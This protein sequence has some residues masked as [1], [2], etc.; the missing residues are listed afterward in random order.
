MI[1]KYEIVRKITC[2]VLTLTLLISIMPSMIADSSFSRATIYVDDDASASWYDATHVKTIQEGINNA[3]TGDTVFVYNGTYYEHIIVNRTVNLIGENNTNTIIDGSDNGDVLTLQ[4]NNITIRSFTIQH[5]GNPPM[6]HS[7][8]FIN[9]NDNNIEDNIIIHNDVYGVNI[10]SASGNIIENNTIRNNGEGVRVFSALSNTISNNIITNNYYGIRTWYGQQNIIKHN[11]ITFSGYYGIFHKECH[12]SQIIN[13]TISNGQNNGYGIRLWNGQQVIIQQNIVM[14]HGIGIYLDSE[15]NNHTIFNNYFDNVNNVQDTGVDNSWNTTLTIGTNI[16]NGSYIGGNYWSDYLGYDSDADG[17]GDTDLPY[18]PGDYLP[19]VEANLIPQAN[20]TYAPSHPSTVDLIQFTDLS[21]DPDGTADI[22]NWTWD[23]GDG[24]ISYEQNATHSY[25]DNGNYTVTLFIYDTQGASNSTQQIITVSNLAPIADFSYN[26]IDPIT[27]DIVSFNSTSVDL[28]GIIVN[29]T[30]DFNDG[31]YGYGENISH[32]FDNGTF[33]VVLWVKDD[34]GSYNV[35]NKTITVTN[36]HPSVDF[37]Y[38][39]LNPTTSDTIYFEDTSSD[40][41]VRSITNW[42]WDFG[43][44]NNSYLQ[45]PTHSYADNGTYTVMLTVTDNNGASN[46]TSKNITVSNVA[47]MASFLFSPLNPTTI[48]HIQFNDT[49]TDSDG[50]VVNWSWDFGDGNNS[51]L[52][53]PTHSYA[54]NGTYIV[55][56]VV[57]DDDGANNATSVMVTVGNTPPI[58]NFSFSPFAPSTADTVLFNDTSFDPDGSVL[59][60]YWDFDDGT[61]NTSQNTSHSFAA[62]G[63]YNVS[64]TVT[65]ND[66]GVNMTT[67]PITVSNIGPTASFTYNPLHPSTADIIQ[68]TDTSTDSDGS[69]VNWTWDFGDGT[70]N[71][72]Q[73]PVHRFSDNGTYNVSL[74]IKDDNGENDTIWMLLNVSNAIPVPNFTWDPVNPTKLDVIQF[75]DL[76]SD[77]SVVSWNWN[78]GDGNLS[79]L[80]NPTH[81]Y[82]DDGLYNVTLIVSDDDGSINS[83]TKLLTV[84]SIKPDANFSYSPNN[85]STED[86]V[87]FTDLS[88]DADGSI[89]NWT[90]DFGDE[91]QSYLQHPSHQYAD[92]GSYIVTLTVVDDDGENDSINGV[93]DV[94]N[95]APSVNFSYLPTV[96]TTADVIQFT[97]L[98][99]DPDGTIVSWY[100]D[101][102]DGYQQTNQHPNNQYADDD[103]YNVSLTVTDDD[104]A[105][106]TTYKLITITNVAPLVS[107]TYTPIH[108]TVDDLILFNDTSLDSDG[109]IVN[110][111]W[112][113]G[114]GNNSY[115]K[116]PSFSYETAGNYTVNLTVRDDDNASN[117]S[118]ITLTI[119][120]RP[121][122]FDE[123]W[124]DDD[125]NSSLWWWQI[126]H[127]DSIQDAIDAVCENGTVYVAPGSYD[128]QLVINKSVTIIGNGTG[129]TIVTNTSTLNEF[130]TTSYDNYPIV[131]IHHTDDVILKNLSV[132]GAGNGNDN[133]RFIGVG[134]YDAGGRLNQIEIKSVR[135]TPWSGAQHGVSVYAYAINGTSRNLIIDNCEIYDYQKNAMSLNGVDLMVEVTNNTIV[136]NGPTNVT[137]Q[138]GIQV[139]S[140]ASGIIDN[141]TIYGNWYTGPIWGASGGLIY[142]SDNITISNN[143]FDTNQM[144]VYYYGENGLIFD[145]EFINNQWAFVLWGDAYIYDNAL[146]NNT[147]NKTYMAE[148]MSSHHCFSSIQNAIDNAVN[149]D[150]IMVYDGVYDEDIIIN[151]EITLSG[152][153]PPTNTAQVNGNIDVIADNATVSKLLITPGNV[154]GHQAA[155]L[156]AASNVTISENHVEGMNG[157]GTGSVKGIHVYSTSLDQDILIENNLISN[158][159]NQGN[160]T[161]YGG[162]TGISIQGVVDDVFLINNS[163]ENIW[164]YGWSYG[165]EVTPTGSH[166]TTPPTNVVI[167]ENTIDYISA[168]VW[169]SY[170][171]CLSVDA[172]NNLYPA[173]ASEITVQYNNFRNSP[174]GAINKDTEHILDAHCNYWDD[175]TGPFHNVSNADGMGCNV[176]DNISFIPWLDDE[177]PIGNCVGGQC[178]DPIWVDDDAA[179]GWYDWDHVSDIQTAM[180]RICVGGT[181]HI[182][183]GVYNEHFTVDKYVKIIGSGSDSNG[184]II[185]Q[186]LA[187]SGDTHVGVVNI[188]ASGLSPMQQL[189]IKD[190]RIKPDQLAG[191]SIGRFNEQ[192]ETDVFYVKLDHVE[193]IGTNTNPNTEQ[194]RGLYVDVN[195]SLRYLEV[196]NASFD[197]LTYGW[198]LHKEVS[199]EES[200]VQY[201]LVENTTFNH[202]NLKGIYAE[203]LSDATLWNCEISNNGFSSLGVPS[204]F[205]PWMS[206]IDINLKAGIYKNID[207]QS[208]LIENNALGGAKEGVGLTIKERGTGSN[209]SSGY[210]SYPAHVDDVTITGCTILGNERGIRFGEPGKNNFGPTNITVINNNIYENVP[211]Y[212]G[213]DGSA[214]G[215]LINVMQSLV[216]STCNWWGNST[217]PY[218]D[219]MNPWGSG[220]NITGNISF[221]PWLTDVFPVGD[222]NGYPNAPPQVSFNYTPSVPTTADIIQFTDLST[223][224]GTIVNW[225]WDFGD[226]NISYLQHPLH[227]FADNDSYNVTLTVT[228]EKNE[229]NMTSQIIIVFNADPT[230][231]F[232]WNP[233]YPS[234]QDVIQFTDLSTDR[235]ID[236]WLWDFGD[237]YHAS[238]QHPTHQYTDDGWYNVTLTVTDDDGATN[239]TTKQVLVENVAPVAEFDF[240]P[241][242]PTTND[243][244]FFFDN[245]SDIDGSVVNWSWDFGDGNSSYESNPTYQYD[246][247]G[248]YSVCLTIIDNDGKTDTMCVFV[249]VTSTVDQI[250]VNQSVF[251]RGFPIRHALDGDWAG[252]QNFTSTA[253]MLTK[254]EIYLRK[255]GTPEFNLTVELRTDGPQGPIIDSIVFNPVD[256]PSSWNWLTLNFTDVII[257][258]DT[259]Y[260]IVCPPAPGG[261]SSSFGYE[262]G[263]AFGNQYDDGSFWFTR[264]GGGLWRDLPQT[265]EFCFKTYG[266]S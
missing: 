15:S 256:V 12:Q 198:Y 37:T 154:T 141:N 112:D 220:E 11:N 195:S 72:T 213:T 143:I 28:D 177:Y 204:H 155:M 255:F 185:T 235:G 227:Q 233:L 38:V 59:S 101:F 161:M 209:P 210:A 79:S 110:W 178:T 244:I 53:D 238:I 122:C 162:S 263:Y 126:T 149:M 168:S 116:N 56:L 1:K 190:V 102:D 258:P 52:Q 27:S 129:S 18:G 196:C 108:P 150:T 130:F 172:Y 251:N 98:S 218:N 105:S 214:Y 217:G 46:S 136:G 230:P 182:A 16:I 95:V 127:F 32:S 170:A 17:I 225:T 163:I 2:F 4:A 156:I 44:G 39:P 180:D 167:E 246:A 237:G 114:D 31:T 240:T 151:K 118:M 187:G 147:Y 265:Y 96:P 109:T 23:F 45:D 80:Q 9:S 97:D 124:V 212:N 134:F 165:V 232:T 219:T 211:Q 245:S 142:A 10:V 64:L 92:N 176:S 89:V 20:F 76:S 133:Y 120:P 123:V 103:I 55:S 88:T 62:S 8:L 249:L 207:I 58:A 93:V 140:D 30:W 173:N 128:E 248:N 186:N 81:Q 253:N 33:N 262:W 158:I 77:R 115:L 91:N 94:S 234:T 74:T 222:C 35:T 194:E 138:N 67:I 183:N 181:I 83:V 197:N 47:P 21:T 22:I 63:I 208:C 171:S 243:T 78:F 239:S 159:S 43:D 203:K 188:I 153:H 84:F 139:G 228:D 231:D 192:T 260:F 61:T 29:W 66:W 121:S 75:Y 257:Q 100:W 191:I 50:S 152:V 199:S 57:M 164:S 201:V 179:A 49:S 247:G 254:A 111:S 131:Y 224:D 169:G 68:F 135:D 189:L 48:D 13:N 5:A 144:A 65:D 119:D 82:A 264:D 60:W 241:S 107:F 24:N 242:T 117:F 175:Y 132:D 184:T 223:D 261:V 40:R 148:I 36:P 69:V 113:F 3:S 226:G 146:V 42:T 166:P 90:W 87:D 216:V 229:S 236:Q 250:D 104:G 7:A 157:D 6:T 137:A 125:F 259:D 51:Y 71:Y 34:V 205:L 215:G 193:V 73:H 99:S 86:L 160:T 174:Y 202:N 41:K 54:D 206:G 19:L 70:I 26:P 14:D 221:I 252:A 25:A 106:N 145:N 200:T 85:P 266:Y